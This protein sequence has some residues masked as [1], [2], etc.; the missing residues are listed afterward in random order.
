G[1]TCDGSQNRSSS[2]ARCDS[3]VRVKVIGGAYT[4]Q[5]CSACGFVHPDNRPSQAAF[6]CLACGHTENTD[7]NAGTLLP[8]P[9]STGLLASAPPT[10]GEED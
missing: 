3:G 10:R 6:R 9:L 5:Q 2:T 8:G 4:S 1:A 7:L